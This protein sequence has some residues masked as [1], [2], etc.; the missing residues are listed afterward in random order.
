MTPPDTVKHPLFHQ[1]RETMIFTE[2]Y[3]PADQTVL[4]SMALLQRMNSGLAETARF[5]LREAV[6]DLRK[7]IS[8]DNPIEPSQ[9]DIAKVASEITRAAEEGDEATSM[10]RALSKELHLLGFDET[11]LSSILL[12]RFDTAA[13][14]A[15]LAEDDKAAP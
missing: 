15:A 2:G 7:M 1:I 10:A 4:L 12:A 5:D 14:R 11:D 9:A 6:C 8:P 3:T 13:L